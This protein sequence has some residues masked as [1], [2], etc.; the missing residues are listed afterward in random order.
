MSASTER[1]V[2]IG[3]TSGIGLAAAEEQLRAGREVII[4]G[5]DKSRLDAALARLGQGASG[6]SLD[7][8][9]E[10]ATHD[11]FAGLDQID[12]VVVAVTGSTAAGPF[13][14]L[15]V[16]DL[17]A[18]A[19]GKLVAQTV[20]AQ[21]ALKALRPGGSITFVTAGSAG[22]ARPGTAGL[23]AV[24]A[25][26]EAMVPVLAVELAPIRV[27]AVSP[28]IIDTPWW[29]WMDAEARQQAFDGFAATA[30]AGRVGRP[31]DIAGAIGYLIGATFTTGVVLSVDGGSRLRPAAL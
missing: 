6:V 8:L 5:R 24:N 20:A 28:G 18:A 29:D 2:V 19:E 15:P 16:A 13:E 3:G 4:A 23:A 11:F 25:A 14:N 12:H 22:S 17:R 10:T 21:G 30:P 1:V 9:D 27:N 26:V 7:A 31:E